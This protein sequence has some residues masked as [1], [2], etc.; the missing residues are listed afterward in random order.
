MLRCALAFFSAFFTVILTTALMA[1]QPVA[2]QPVFERNF[3][4]NALRGQ[5]SFGSIP[6][7]AVL[8]EVKTRLAPGARIFGQNNMMV[9]SDTLRGQTFVVHYTRDLLGQPKDIWLLRPEEITRTPWPTTL[10]EARTWQFN[11]TTQIWTKP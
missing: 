6:P 5:L 3:P 1:P 7:E 2:A 4:Q 9:M 10:D 11:T 8:N